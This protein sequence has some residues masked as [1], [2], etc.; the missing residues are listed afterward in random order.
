MATVFAPKISVTILSVEITSCNPLISRRADLLR[1]TLREDRLPREG[2][3]RHAALLQGPQSPP[4]LLPAQHAQPQRGSC[5]RRKC[6][7]DFLGG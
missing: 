6:S 3:H 2:G 7:P 5:H 4:A 1:G